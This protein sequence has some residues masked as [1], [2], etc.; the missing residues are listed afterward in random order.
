[1]AMK[2]LKKY[3]ESIEDWTVQKFVDMINIEL[4]DNPHFEIQE[5][6]INNMSIQSAIEVEPLSGAA[7]E[8]RSPV[9]ISIVEKFNIEAYNYYD[10]E[11]EEKIKIINQSILNKLSRKYEFSIIGSIKV[12]PWSSPDLEYE[13][14]FDVFF[15]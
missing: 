11:W 8:M 13:V 1:M 10:H 7:V 12:L 4:E 15:V 3:N 9:M 2:Y 5:I 6:Y 14:L